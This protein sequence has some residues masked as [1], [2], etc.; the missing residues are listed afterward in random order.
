MID[1]S[2]SIFVFLLVINIIGIFEKLRI[3]VHILNPSLLGKFISNKIKSGLLS[4]TICDILLKSFGFKI[5]YPFAISKFPIS[6]CNC[7]LSS[8]TII[9][10]MLL[11]PYIICFMLLIILS[12]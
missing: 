6:F 4:F 9:V 10:N 1:I 5:E 11:S 8:T 12:Y 3:S 7:S 2:S